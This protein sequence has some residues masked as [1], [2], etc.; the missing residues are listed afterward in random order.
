MD[1]QIDNRSTQEVRVG[2]DDQEVAA[3]RKVSFFIHNLQGRVEGSDYLLKLAAPWNGF[4]YQLCRGEQV[5]ASAKRRSRMHAFEPDRPFVRHTLTEFELDL[6]SRRMTLT[7]EDRRGI[8]FRLDENGQARGRLAM[9]PFE[10]Q[11]DGAWP[12]D[13]R[14]PDGWSVPLAAFVAW[15]AREG[16]SRMSK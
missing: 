9:R 7:P 13:L 6:V 8:S 2:V 14:A 16:R 12:A 1:Y 10:V 3:F 11:R 5:V 15:L 4:R